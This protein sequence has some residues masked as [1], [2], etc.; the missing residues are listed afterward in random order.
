MFRELGR[1]FGLFSHIVKET[2]RNPAITRCPSCG[3]WISAG[4][5][6]CLYCG[7]LPAHEVLGVEPDAPAPAVR[8]AARKRLLAT[9]PDRG[10]SAVEFQRV[11]SARDQLLAR[12]DRP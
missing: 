9:H 11:L 8:A 7:Y 10:G 6:F 1:Q 2:A 12:A 3:A 5:R 4:G